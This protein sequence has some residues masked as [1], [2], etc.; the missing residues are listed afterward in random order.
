VEVSY[1]AT[2]NGKPLESGKLDVPTTGVWVADLVCVDDS[3]FSD[4]ATLVVQDDTW[5]G[6]VLSSEAIG[7]KT[8]ARVLGGKAKWSATVSKR[9][10]ANDAGVKA[11]VITNDLA[12]AIGES[13]SVTDW[14]V[15]THWSRFSGPASEALKSLAGERGWWVDRDGKTIVNGTRPTGTIAAD[16]LEFDPVLG[17]VVLNVTSLAA[18]DIGK[19]ITAPTLAAPAPVRCF[20]AE[21]GADYLKVTISTREGIGGDVPDALAAIIKA[22]TAGIYPGVYRYRVVTQAAGRLAVQAITSGAPDLET[23]HQ[24]PGVPGVE[25]TLQLGSELLVM[26]EGGSPTSPIVVGYTYGSNSK[27]QSLTICG[28]GS[29]AARQNDSVVVT[30]SPAIFTGTIGGSPATGVVQ[31]AVPQAQ[32]VITS[33]SGKVQIG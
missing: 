9:G 15:G 11:S 18:I 4:A 29:P 22:A 6:T 13:V 16:V 32:G 20:M 21:F 31:W 8:H 33:G 17:Q 23:L 24:F 10:Y 25:T 7:G 12:A 19:S 3:A 28:P 30:M 2:L 14:V 5:S 1:L 26:F 27:P